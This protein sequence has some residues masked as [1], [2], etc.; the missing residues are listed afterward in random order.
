MRWILILCI[1]LWAL[2]PAVA[3]DTAPLGDSYGKRVAAVVA[4]AESSVDVALAAR[5][6]GAAIYFDLNSPAEQVP[7]FASMAAADRAL[8]RAAGQTYALHLALGGAPVGRFGLI[9]RQGSR[10][11]IG[12]DGRGGR[13]VATGR[14]AVAALAEAFVTPVDTSSEVAAVK[15][16]AESA[17]ETDPLLCPFHPNCTLHAAAAR[18]DAIVPRGATASV[19]FKGVGFSDAGNGP[20]PLADVGLDVLSTAFLAENRIRLD[21]AIAEDATLGVHRIEVFNLGS[22][23]RAAGSYAI[24]VIANEA[25]IVAIADPGYRSAMLLSPSPRTDDHGDNEAAASDVAVQAEGYLERSGDHDMFR[26]VV[27]KARNVTI[28][29]SGP[30][31]VAG[32]LVSEFGKVWAKDDDSGDWYNFSLNSWLDAGTYYLRVRHCCGGVGPYAV[33][34]D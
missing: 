9:H 14:Q 16:A 18:V 13:W 29:S 23:F 2:M 1:A 24:K 6:D 3:Q 12:L 34:I 21:L 19:E 15:R 30:S 8:L 31:D 26:F 20:F 7:G 25:E 11:Y 22:A 4:T 33:R 28:A 27:P 32:T 10:L 5:A 17:P